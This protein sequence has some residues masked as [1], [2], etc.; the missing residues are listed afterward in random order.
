LAARICGDDVQVIAPHG[1]DD[2]VGMIVR[3]TPA[4]MHKM[5]LIRSRLASKDWARRWPRLQ[6]L[7]A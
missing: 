1:L 2:L 7:D 6:F 5:P 4:F 3:P